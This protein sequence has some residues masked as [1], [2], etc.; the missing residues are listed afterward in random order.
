MI[1]NESVQYNIRSW[2]PF[3]FDVDRRTAVGLRFSPAGIQIVVVGL[4]FAP[5]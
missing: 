3:M 1:T 4:H 5:D 2:K